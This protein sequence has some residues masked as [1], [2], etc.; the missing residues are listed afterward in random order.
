MCDCGPGQFACTSFPE[1]GTNCSCI[2]A[3]WHCDSDDD[4]GN[5]SDELGCGAYAG[6]PQ[7]PVKFTLQLAFLVV[8]ERWRLYAKWKSASSSDKTWEGSPTANRKQT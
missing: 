2:P 7:R 4:C 5:G 8:Q 1:D 3:R 6:R